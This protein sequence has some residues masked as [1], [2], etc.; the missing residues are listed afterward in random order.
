MH[1]YFLG[2]RNIFNFSGRTSRKEFA[3]YVLIQLLFA[4]IFFIV[5]TIK[6]L[7]SYPMPASST[8]RIIFIGAAFTHFLFFPAAIVRRLHD[9][10]QS[11]WWSILSIFFLLSF[12]SFVVTITT[13]FGGLE[14]F[15]LPADPIMNFFNP[16]FVFSSRVVVF[17]FLM[18]IF[19]LFKNG[20]QI[21][22]QGN[23]ELLKK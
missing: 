19:I 20:T 23:S 16:I 8:M 21:I 7:D 9:I 1:D 15:V 11:G 3:H 17:V 2:L 10:D 14:G 22:D 12:C 6:I 4:V 5:L 18:A 13:P